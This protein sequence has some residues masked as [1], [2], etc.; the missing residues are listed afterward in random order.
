[1]EFLLGLLID[2]AAVIHSAVSSSDHRT[3][4]KMIAIIIVLFLIAVGVVIA[5]A[6]CGSLQPAAGN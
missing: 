6:G 5:L 1:M 3:D 2:L 4:W